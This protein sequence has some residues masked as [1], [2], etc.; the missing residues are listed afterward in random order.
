M[1]PGLE[2]FP[3]KSNPSSAISGSEIRQRSILYLVDDVSRYGGVRTRVTE[4]IGCLRGSPWTRVCMISRCNM[5]NIEAIGPAVST[6]RE[7]SA[8]EGL[9]GLAFPKIPH[10]GLPLLYELSFLLNSLL[11]MLIVAPLMMTRRFDLVYGHNNELGALVVLLGRLFGVP[12]AVDLHGVE[13]DEYLEAYPEMRRHPG[14]VRFWKTVERFVLR[15]AGTV[16]CVSNAHLGEVKSRAGVALRA[17]VLPCFADERTFGCQGRSREDVRRSLGVRDDE[18]LL[19]YA[20]LVPERR[21]EFDPIFFFS[22]L[23]DTSSVRLMV[24]AP[25]PGSVERA[26]RKIA[27]S[28]ADKVLILSVP[29]PLMPEYLCAGDCAILLRRQSIVHRV[30]SPTKFAEYLLCGLPVIISANVGDASAL[31]KEHGIG[32]VIPPDTH[33]DAISSEALRALAGWDSRDRA[34][35]VGLANLSRGRCRQMFL[36]ILDSAVERRRS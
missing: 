19:A 7:E 18:V 20:G 27:P 22:S 34:R 35:A 21:D 28:I 12:T 32:L 15:R 2:G 31:V 36:D 30:A 9:R 11:L 4:E 6:I 33:A 24:L 13:V 25:D 8:V 3:A 10:G 23:R 29:R 26:R 17:H 14:R 5:S 16:V 1:S